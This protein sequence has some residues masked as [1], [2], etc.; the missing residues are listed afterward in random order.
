MLRIEG[1]ARITAKGASC[2]LSTRGPQIGEP[3]AAELQGGHLVL[4]EHAERVA[5]AAVPAVP[6]A[7]RL[8]VASGAARTRANPREGVAQETAEP[9]ERLAL[10][11]RLGA[12]LPGRWLRCEA[13]AQAR[14]VVGSGSRVARA[15]EE[16]PDRDEHAPIM[17]PEARNLQSSP[18]TRHPAKWP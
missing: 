9:S 14:E 10:G 5:A 2:L 12:R 8:G 7:R 13:G 11:A 1:A 6:A 15:I 4:R 3:R 17:G 16:L 18:P